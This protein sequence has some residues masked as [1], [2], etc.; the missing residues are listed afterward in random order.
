MVEGFSFLA[1]K[2]LHPIFRHWLWGFLLLLPQMCTNQSAYQPYV[3]DRYIQLR[4]ANS[5]IQVLKLFG[6]IISMRSFPTHRL[7]FS[8]CSVVRA[9]MRSLTT[10]VSLSKSQAMKSIRVFRLVVWNLCDVFA[11]SSMSARA[12]NSFFTVPRLT[13]DTEILASSSDNTKQHC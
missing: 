8:P 2:K 6:N 1:K 12:P 5:F 13:S 7:K 4:Q 9:T 11:F 3:Q 10:Q